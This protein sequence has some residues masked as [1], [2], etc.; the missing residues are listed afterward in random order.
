MKQ[1]TAKYVFVQSE[2]IPELMKYLENL[3][4]GGVYIYDLEDR[5][6]DTIFII[7]GSYFPCLYEDMQKELSKD[8]WTDCG[9]S[10]YIFKRLAEMRSDTEINQ[11]F[12]HKSGAHLW[13]VD[14][15]NKTFENDYMLCNDDPECKMEDF[16]RASQKELYDYFMRCE[17]ATL[18]S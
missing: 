4:Y 6:Y 2:Q 11:W 1:F 17:K 8:I 10:T 15:E 12:I 9:T 18:P 7:D 13:Q 5:D 14:E 3:G 16:H